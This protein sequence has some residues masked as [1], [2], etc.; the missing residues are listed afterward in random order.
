MSDGRSPPPSCEA[1]DTRQCD[2]CFEARPL[3]DFV[4][5]HR[6]DATPPPDGR[7]QGRRRR[8]PPVYEVCRYCVVQLGD[9]RPWQPYRHRHLEPIPA[10]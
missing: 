9:R 1:E 7:V 2:V 10:R 5:V 4:N 8:D 6:G 3:Q